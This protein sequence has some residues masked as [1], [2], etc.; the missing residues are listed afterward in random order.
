MRNG[1]ATAANALGQF[2]VS[3]SIKRELPSK[4][5]AMN[6]YLQTLAAVLKGDLDVLQY[7]EQLDYDSIIDRE[8]LF[9]RENPTLNPQQRRERIMLLP[10][11]VRRQRNADQQ[12]IRLRAAIEHLAQVHAALAADAQHI[13]PKSLKDKLADLA[14]AGNN[15]GTFYSSLPEK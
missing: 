7:Q 11:I 3:R 6:D 1:I 4:V 13:A 15:L 10:E 5:Q 2:L 12:I 9:I 8:T 14:A